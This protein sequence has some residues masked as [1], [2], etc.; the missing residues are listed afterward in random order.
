MSLPWPVWSMTPSQQSFSFCFNW[1]IQ[2]YFTKLQN[3]IEVHIKWSRD[4]A[5][6]SADVGCSETSFINAGTGY[7]SKLE[8]FTQL[9]VQAD[10]TVLWWSSLRLVLLGVR[11]E[12]LWTP[13]LPPA[14]TETDR[15]S[16]DSSHYANLQHLHRKLLWSAAIVSAVGW[17]AL[18]SLPHH[19]KYLHC[20][21]GTILS[22][23]V[24]CPRPVTNKTFGPIVTLSQ[25]I[26]LS[27]ENESL[28]MRFSQELNLIDLGPFPAEQSEV[29]QR[30]KKRKYKSIDV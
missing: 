23:L 28:F 2:S 25:G 26:H 10:C 16:I 14:S 20:R 18:S 27:W 1:I 9:Q 8:L 19:N 15:F 12:M 6:V 29:V 3:T 21:L 11:R 5:A 24:F 22:D 17:A 4:R 30:G 7:W 13:G